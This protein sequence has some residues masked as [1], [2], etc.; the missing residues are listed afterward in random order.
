MAGT[1]RPTETVLISSNYQNRP[2]LNLWD[3][4]RPERLVS[5]MSIKPILL[6]ATLASAL[7]AQLLG[8]D[9]KSVVANIGGKDITVAE[10]QRLLSSADPT[11]V[12]LYQQDPIHA[13]ADYYTLQSLASIA[14]DR[15]LDQ[16]GEIK[17]LI[18]F[19]T[20]TILGRA[21]VNDERNEFNV[22]V[23]DM[24]AYYKE[25]IS[26]YEQ[27]KI[28]VIYLPFKGVV[29]GADPTTAE[30]IKQLT[31][32]NL[33]MAHASHTEDEAKALAEDIVKKLRAGGDFAKLAE[34]YSED[35]TSKATGGDFGYVKAGSSL[36]ADFQKAVMALNAGEIGDPIRQ[37][38]AFYVVQVV[39]KSAQPVDEVRT[40][41]ADAI[42]NNHFNEWMQSVIAHNQVSVKDPDFFKPKQ[43]ATSST[44]PAAPPH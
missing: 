7:S 10:V 37:P 28:K 6:A 3:S 29:R 11:W 18:D 30:G 23:E 5:P 16:Q 38:A 4:P 17:D 42:R 33:E 9:P 12:R 13:L 44:A 31:Q 25:H 41:I 22:T 43:P 32:Q 21:A 40:P 19:V 35:A 8:P 26:D 36:P 24:D 14:K 27:V 2:M 34:Q 20:T 39:E 1:L 15:K